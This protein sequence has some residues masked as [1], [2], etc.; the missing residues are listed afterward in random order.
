[1]EILSTQYPELQDFIEKN[2]NKSVS[3]ILR[4]NNISMGDIKNLLSKIR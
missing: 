4:E 3:Q 1:M 2:R